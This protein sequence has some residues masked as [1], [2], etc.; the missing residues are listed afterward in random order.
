MDIWNKILE[1][2]TI[3][4]FRVIANQWWG[5][6]VHFYDKSGNHKNNGIPF[7]NCHC[8]LMQTKKKA[9]KDCHLSHTENLKVSN[10]TCKII[11]CKFCE[12]FR[13]VV[14]PIFARGGYVGSIMCTGMQPPVIK[15]L[16]E[17]SINKLARLGFVKK[18]VRQCYDK[19][20]IADRHTEDEVIK[21]MKL[22]SID[23]STFF[24]TLLNEKEI[25]DEQALLKDWKQN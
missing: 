4:V 8:A 7:Q 13:A 24:N 12:N 23:I 22:V 15:S 11:T 5:L 1:S 25:K 16:Q 10:K 20:R 17:Q 9:E 19:I 14:F 2:H 6:D 18:E 3:K 21:F